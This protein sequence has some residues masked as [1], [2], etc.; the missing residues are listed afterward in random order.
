MWPDL[1]R[2]SVQDADYLNHTRLFR[3][4]NEL[5]YFAISERLA[6]FCQVWCGCVCGWVLCGWVHVQICVY[7]HVWCLSAYNNEM[8]VWYQ[9]LATCPSTMVCPPPSSSLLAKCFHLSGNTSGQLYI[10]RIE[11]HYHVRM[12][13]GERNFEGK[14]HGRL[15]QVV[16]VLPQKGLIQL[17]KYKTK[18]RHQSLIC[19]VCTFATEEGPVELEQVY[20]VICARILSPTN[21]STYCTKS[22]TWQ[23]RCIGRGAVGGY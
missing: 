2:P 4:S 21:I 18:S 16:G 23:S 1:P 19:F 5:G 9:Q 12:L 7:V 15:V 20:N 8:C 13:V 17:Q 22:C 6:D 10:C 11:I 3:C 14:S